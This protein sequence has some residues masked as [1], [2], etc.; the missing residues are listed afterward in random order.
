VRKR[1]PIE[2]TPASP[3]LKWAGGK[4]QLLHYILPALPDRIDTYYEP[5]I[6]GGAVFFALANERRFKRAV[7]ADR[8]PNLIECYRVIQK[9]VG[10]LIDALETH[11][12][13]ATDP[14]YYY[15]I[16]A[17]D[18]EP[19]APVER[20]AR[21]IFL[22]KTCYNG[23]YRVNRR[24][25]FNVPFG[26]Y[27][28]PRVLNQEALVA[29]SH[30]LERVEI[31]NADFETVSVKAGRGDAIYFDPP[32]H[33]VSPT[34]SFTAYH[35]NVFGVREHERLAEVYGECLAR[36]AVAVLSNS[37]VPLTR[38]LFRDFEVRTV[39]ATRAINSVASRRGQVTEILVV[40][41]GRA[42]ARAC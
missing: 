40:G 12:E 21:I 2:T 26:R 32:Y 38:K 30:A 17:L 41:P 22:N 7:I 28:N 29:A 31:V 39:E 35:S 8:N 6:G 1:T 27:A 34:A 11:A 3:F 33:P 36:G 19:L 10:D 20:A 5:F 13:H 24:G 15:A 37:D 42:A 23:L 25:E 14:E 4:T 18:P 16:R 9:H